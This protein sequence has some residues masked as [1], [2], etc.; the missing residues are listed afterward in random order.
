M[1]TGRITKVTLDHAPINLDRDSVMAISGSKLLASPVW[2]GM[3]RMTV[4]GST[5]IDSPVDVWGA[6]ATASTSSFLRS[7]V[8]T[9]YGGGITI[10]RST[11]DGTGF[12][13]APGY[14][15]ETSLIITNSTVKNFAQP[16]SGWW[17]YVELTGDT[18]TN[19]A[20]GALSDTSDGFESGFIS[21]RVA[22]STFKTSGIA[23][24]V[25]AA[26]LT[27]NTF[28][29]NI[30]GLIP[31][32]PAYT[33]VTGNT[34]SN[35]SSSGIK[36]AGDGLTLKNNTAVNNGRYGIYAPNAV[37]LGGNVAYGNRLTQC[38]GLTCARR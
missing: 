1:R 15:S 12:T 8:V 26:V 25:G 16:I 9:T 36:V 20:R 21:A 29:R 31:N 6:F 38:V 10:D 19:N 30:T 18:F 14:C 17:C 13:Q 11:L 4:T 27:G 3:S 22:N 28:D 24:Q 7:P 35:N 5:F 32:N 34:F 33:T 23:V 2:D 37:D